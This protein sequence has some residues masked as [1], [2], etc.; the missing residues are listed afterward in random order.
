MVRWSVPRGD[1]LLAAALTVIGQIELILAADQ[2]HGPAWAQHIGFALMTLPVAGGRAA[3]LPAV[4]VSAVG[5]VIQSWAGPAPV[6]A[7]FVA[8]LVLLASLGYHGTRRDGVIGLGCMLAAGA[9]YEVFGANLVIGDLIVNVLILGIAWFGAHR[10]RLH[11]DARV[12]AEIAADRAA[13]DAVTAERTRIARDLHD[14]VAHTLTL[15]ALQSAVVREQTG[16][17]STGRRPD[18]DSD[19]AVVD[20]FRSIEDLARAGLDD[21]HRFL[22]VLGADADEGAPGITDLAALV[23]GVQ[24]SGHEVRLSVQGSTDHVP[25]SVG[26]TVYRVVQEALTNSVKHTAGSATTVTL[27]TDDTRVRVSVAD[28]EPPHRMTPRA[29][30]AG[31]GLAGIGE[32]VQLFGGQLTAGP[33]HGDHGWVV[34]ADLPL[35]RGH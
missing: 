34:T 16:I 2:V 23:E 24:R 3:P 8:I 26:T 19:R 18:H 22:H 1:L 17:E 5:L 14:S 13:R 9:A 21:M 30:G 32:R 15:I 28:V 7:G 35:R 20:G 33:G 12:E 25:A 11:A 27:A 31:R 6:A 10:I 4:L 29:D